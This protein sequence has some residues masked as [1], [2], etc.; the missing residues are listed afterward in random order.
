MPNPN[1]VTVPITAPPTAEPAFDALALAM[2]D[3]ATPC[4]DR[5][6]FSSDSPR[7]QATARA[8][9]R[10]CPILEPCHAY[11]SKAEPHGMTWAGVTYIARR[12]G[13]PRKAPA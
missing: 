12:P 6:E 9:C 4:R 1:V 2:L 13:R 7:D 10:D 8:L 11:A 5:L 3:H